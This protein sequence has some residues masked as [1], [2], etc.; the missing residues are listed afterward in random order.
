MHCFDCGG[1]IASFKTNYCS[2]CGTDVR[3][4]RTLMADAGTKMVKNPN[5]KGKRE[6]V[7]EEYAEWW[8]AQ[9]K[10]KAK[11]KKKDEK[12]K[13][14]TSDAVPDEWEPVDSEGEG[15]KYPRKKNIGEPVDPADPE[16]LKNPEFKGPEDD[17]DAVSDDA[18]FD[19][20][21][22]ALLDK[23]AQNPGQD[24]DL[25]EVAVPGT[26]LF[27][28]NNLG[29]PR[30]HMP[31]LGGEFEPGSPVAKMVEEGTLEADKKGEVKIEGLFKQALEE[32]GVKMKDTTI[33]ADRLKSTQAQLVGDK[34]AGM[35]ATLKGERT[36]FTKD[37]SDEELE[38]AKKNIMAPIFV[39]RDGYILDGHHR[40]AAQVAYRMA[41]GEPT[42][43]KVVAVDMDIDDLVDATNEY[44]TQMGIKQ[45]AAQPDQKAAS[46]CRPCEQA[47]KASR[48]I[49]CARE[50][51]TEKVASTWIRSWEERR[52]ARS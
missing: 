43:M 27:C 29:I 19:R 2:S 16:A 13:A 17:D 15:K 22:V 45:K 12:G 50:A 42:K 4:A 40:W 26:N 38:A 34:V 49:P 11:P 35:L 20:G 36:K 46:R 14:D 52:A 39:S 24:K 28:E 1:R 23:L 37:K 30:K 31:Q 8:L 21:V 9:N 3:V 32:K 44:A 51:L 25:C 5:P 7:T 10:G 48:F 33:S 6:M 41:K 18:A 47:K